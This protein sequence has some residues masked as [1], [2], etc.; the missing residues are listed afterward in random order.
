MNGKFGKK[1]FHRN[2]FPVNRNLQ[3][4]RKKGQ[5]GDLAERLWSTA[6]VFGIVDIRDLAHKILPYGCQEKGRKGA[7]SLHD[8]DVGKFQT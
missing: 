6:L 7:K 5:A 4:M 2:G 8:D 1:Q 3:Q